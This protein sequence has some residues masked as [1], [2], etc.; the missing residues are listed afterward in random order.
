M[1]V[2]CCAAVCD[3]DAIGSG[4]YGPSYSLREELMVFEVIDYS[5]L[6]SDITLAILC[7]C[8]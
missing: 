6:R 3:D 4:T 1:F 5:A 7:R 8:C 2:Q